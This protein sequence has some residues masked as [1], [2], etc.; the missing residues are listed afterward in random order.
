MRS[1]LFSI[2]CFVS[3]LAIADTWSDPDWKR[4]LNESHVITIARVVEGGDF[5]AK[6]KILEIL[7]G[8]IST[9]EIW[10][11]GF[12]NKYGPIDN[13]RIGQKYC[14]FLFKSDSS[15]YNSPYRSSS[16][17]AGKKTTKRAYESFNF[18]MSQPNGYYTWTPTA[19]TYRI[20]GNRIKYDLLQTSEFADY[21]FS[22]LNL[23]RDFLNAYFNLEKRQDFQQGIIRN[24]PALSQQDSQ[25][26]AQSL[27]ML[28][29]TGYS[30][31]IEPLISL[32]DSG[33][34]MNRFALC[35]Q[36]GNIK[37]Q[38][39]R[40]LLEKLLLDVSGIVQGEAVRQ[41]SK[42]EPEIVGP[43]FLSALNS[44][45]SQGAY[46]SLMNPVRNSLDGGQLELIRAL[47]NIQYQEATEALLPLLRTKH[48]HIFGTVANSLIKIGI[49]N[50]AWLPELEWHFNNDT[51]GQIL[52]VCRLITKQEIKEAKPL[53]MEYIT[54]HD[55]TIHP[56]KA[57][58]ISW[59]GGLGYFDDEETRQFL[60][61]EFARVLN[62]PKPDTFIDNKDDWVVA[63]IN[64]F[65][66][67]KIEG[68]TGGIR[69]YLASDYDLQTEKVNSPV[70][71]AYFKYLVV[72]STQDDLDYLNEVRKLNLSDRELAKLDEVIAAIQQ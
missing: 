31:L 39:S 59:W 23:F 8:Q 3:T 27:M 13:M 9:K 57:Y 46:P 4:M 10:V 54:S 67:L 55:K 50:E 21:D 20:R 52:R 30:Q 51:A 7:K 47:G 61:D 69:T 38:E 71:N 19:G 25:K 33:H 17:N 48:S 28:Y 63:F 12:S 18:V 22:P 53:L 45:S 34:E 32:A 11:T 41:L 24:L 60:K 26:A 62:M 44:A 56:D 70:M 37:S 72:S 49:E 66:R 65:E 14:L 64:T 35:K 5:K 1:I 40:E 29:L 36:L 58:T 68:M 16:N 6:F 43:L 15:K 42:Y 2:S